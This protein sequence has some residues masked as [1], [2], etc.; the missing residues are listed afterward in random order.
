MTKVRF[1]VA[2]VDGHWIVSSEDGYRQAHTDRAQA[3]HMAVE[4]AHEAGKKGYEAQVLG[5]DSGSRLYPIWTYGLDGFC[6]SPR[7]V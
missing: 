1:I 3:I 5:V 7:S 4:V 2:P 6:A